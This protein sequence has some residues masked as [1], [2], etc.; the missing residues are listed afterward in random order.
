MWAETFSDFSS[1]LLH[2]PGFKV[3]IYFQIMGGE[4]KNSLWHLAPVG[5]ECER[6]PPWD[7]THT[8]TVLIPIVF[9]LKY[10]LMCGGGFDILTIDSA[11]FIF[12]AEW[13][14][15]ML[16]MRLT[17]DVF[18][19]YTAS[20]WKLRRGPVPCVFYQLVTKSWSVL[21]TSPFV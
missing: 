11:H 16:I 5:Q 12:I 20:W 21:L 7:T 1:T 18:T 8:K 6:S 10:M 4:R 19:S 14:G 2:S 13:S 17:L 15:I 9:C 3:R